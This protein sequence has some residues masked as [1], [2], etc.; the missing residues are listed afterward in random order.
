MSDCGFELVDDSH[1]S[2]SKQGLE[3]GEGQFDGIEVGAVGRQI[4][5]LRPDRFD[6]FSYAGHFVGR[7]VIHNHRVSGA[8]RSHELLLDVGA[9]D[10]SVDRPI[11]D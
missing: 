10:G 11:D 5:E 7:Q 1:G 4:D 8:K 9:E 6:G 2:T 3:F